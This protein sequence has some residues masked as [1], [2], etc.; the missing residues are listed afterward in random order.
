MFRVRVRVNVRVNVWRR[1]EDEAGGGQDRVCSAGDLRNGVC[2]TL[3]TIRS[4]TRALDMEQAEKQRLENAARFELIEC[5]RMVQRWRSGDVSLAST[6]KLKFFEAKLE[7]FERRAEPVSF[8]LVIGLREISH[9]V[10][11]KLDAATDFGA[12]C[13]TQGGALGDDETRVQHARVLK[14]NGYYVQAVCVI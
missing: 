2:H 10:K 13:R 11:T 7:A 9:S 1:R 12:L 8:Y 14:T 5:E 3:L 4:A 6:I